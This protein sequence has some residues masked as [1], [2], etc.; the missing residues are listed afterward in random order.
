M[1][2]DQRLD[3]LRREDRLERKQDSRPVYMLSEM[4]LRQLLEI[5]SEKIEIHRQSESQ[6]EPT[7]SSEKQHFALLQKLNES[8][9]S[10]VENAYREV[11]N[12]KRTVIDWLEHRMKYIDA[13]E[14][15][16]LSMADELVNVKTSHNEKKYVSLEV[17]WLDL[18][19]TLPEKTQLILKNLPLE[20]RL[21][22]AE[23]HD[24]H[25]TSKLLESTKE[26]LQNES[27]EKRV[28]FQLRNA[29]ETISQKFRTSSERA[30]KMSIHAVASKYVYD[31]L[32]ALKMQ[33]A[34]YN[35][36][37]RTLMPI[38]RE[39]PEQKFRNRLAKLVVSTVNL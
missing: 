17:E 9:V 5:G 36:K 10:I 19:Q 16:Y 2:I 7:T 29:A 8:V 15:K 21:S 4:L 14:Q 39:L 33:L 30:A 32:S 11:N 13:L 20:E 28:H 35:A 38:G 37:K 3:E 12:T 18:I 22:F 25:L 1:N 26:S 31:G 24:I 27:D 34:Q 6:S 23:A